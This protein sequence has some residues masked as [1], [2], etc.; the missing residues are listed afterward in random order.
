MYA[1]VKIAVQLTHSPYSILVLTQ[2]ATET[3][4]NT[5]MTELVISM[6]IKYVQV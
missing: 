1:T 6:N 2:K 5:R 4:K 3:V